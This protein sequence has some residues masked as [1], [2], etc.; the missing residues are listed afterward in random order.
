MTSLFVYVSRSNAV[1]FMPGPR[2]T[3]ETRSL[4][5]TEKRPLGYFFIRS[6]WPAVVDSTFGGGGAL[7]VKKTRTLGGRSWLQQL[8][9]GRSILIFPT[10]VNYYFYL[11][12][13][14]VRGGRLSS[15]LKYFCSGGFIPVSSQLE[16][17]CYHSCW[18]LNQPAVEVI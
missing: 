11:Q 10:P 13:L 15:L 14:I 8:Q 17:S 3:P 4:R 9:F 12:Y 5:H 7:H 6:H 2:I 18:M 1:K 16:R